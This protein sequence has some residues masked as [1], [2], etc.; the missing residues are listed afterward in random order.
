MNKKKLLS[1]TLLSVLASAVF[2]SSSLGTVAKDKGL[3]SVVNDDWAV[4][5]AP[6][7]EATGMPTSSTICMNTAN[8]TIG[9]SPQAGMSFN[10]TASTLQISRSLNLGLGFDGLQLYGITVGA[11][12]SFASTTKDTDYTYNYTYL[13]TYSTKANMTTTY[14]NENLSTSGKNAL[15]VSEAAFFQTCG[16]SF[17]SNLD[18]GAVIAVNVS[19]TFKTREQA[20]AFKGSVSAGV[21]LINIIPSLKVSGST[22]TKDAV[23]TVSALQNGGTPENLNNIFGKNP[24]T[25]SYNI[26]ACGVDS[27]AACQTLINS[28]ISYSTTLGSQVKNAD[29]MIV[30]NLFY[31]NPVLTSYSSVGVTVPAPKPLSSSAINAQNEVFE[32]LNLSTNRIAF[33]SHYKGDSLPVQPDLNSYIRSQTKTLQAR[34]DYINSKAV[35]CFNSYAET[36]PVIA[37]Q[38]RNTFNN[39]KS[40]YNFD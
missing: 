28:I 6:T 25:G 39:S 4:L 40:T 16:D 17:V 7:L 14:G 37:E 24:E 22:I 15:A 19:I 29:G 34:V 38:M 8:V 13:Y 2:A 26:S 18:A 30:S 5:G 1:A 32:E 10:S 12:A 36:C 23:I 11:N 3:Q 9:N 20:N 27:P 31:S 33:L 21:S 35:N